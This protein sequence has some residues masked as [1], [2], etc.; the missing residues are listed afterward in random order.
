MK[1]A[2][3]AKADHPTLSVPEAMRVATFTFDESNNHNLQMRVHR[4]SLPPPQAINVT[5]SSPSSTV[6]TLTPT[7]STLPQLKKIRRTSSGAQQNRANELKIKLHHKAAHKRATSLYA[8]E[9]AK[10]E[11]EKKM[12]ASEVSKLV[13]GEFG[14]EIH[15]RTIQR[16]VAED[17]VG[18]SPKK[19]G[20][21]GVIP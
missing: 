12:S 13:L 14:V 20:P 6:S 18:M 21:E 7:T 5:D 11:G 2:S 16:E 3:K 15:K 19:R 4:A 10:P 8:S 9:L 1:R 17:R